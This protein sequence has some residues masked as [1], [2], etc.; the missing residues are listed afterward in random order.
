MNSYDSSTAD[1]QHLVIVGNGMATGRL[2]DELLRRDSARRF[3]ITVVGDEPEG[4][5]NRIMLSPVLAG[6]S[7][8]QSI[9]Q[10]DPDW[11]ARQGIT[12]LAGRRGERIVPERSQL[13]L[14]DGHTLSYDQL[15]I[16]TGSKPARIPAGNQHL[17]N[18]FSFRTLVDVD[19]I[20]DA[21]CNAQHAVV[22]GGGLLGLEAAYGLAQK[23]MAVTVVHRG[24]WLLNRQLDPAAGGMLRD[25]LATKQIRF[26]L[27]A[28]VATFDGTDTVTA[29]TLNNGRQLACD[30]AVIA[31]GI[32]PNNGL[33][34]SGGLDCGQGIKVDSLLTTSVPNI[35]ALGECC[36]YQGSTFGLV[37]P[38]WHQC[39][40]LADRLS[41]GMATPFVNP[42][43]ATKLKV[44]GVQLYS[45]GD[46]LTAKHHREIVLSD[47]AS[48]VYRKLL[49]SRDTLV[50]VVLFGDTR[51]GNAYF[52]TLTNGLPLPDTLS[53]ITLGQSFQPLARP[54]Q[55]PQAVFNS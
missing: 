37:E 11:F 48:R 3:A 33:G 25:V 16:A 40:T 8:R 13:T 21:S 50:G 24:Q 30:L 41:L 17:A 49:F 26:E 44:S 28:E 27:G 20:L 6:E 38:I 4:S 52:E 51:D 39:I 5:Y 43:V 42:Q 19:T 32:T 46:H 23:G 15:V 14:D 9:I 45:A 7:K 31:T 35:S 47:P 53:A 22:V 1:L 2:L 29:V 18:I 36:E 12:F 10:K 54:H 55:Q 34:L